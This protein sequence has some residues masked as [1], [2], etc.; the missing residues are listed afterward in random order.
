M[1]EVAE[2]S[3]IALPVFVL[4]AARLAKVRDRGELCV[5]R[6][7]G[8]PPVVQVLN[9]SLRFSFPF[10]TSVHVA[11]QMVTHVVAYLL[12]IVSAITRMMKDYTH[13]KFKKVSKLR[14]LAV[15]VL[16]NR[17]KSLLKLLRGQTADRIVG[18]VMVHVREQNGLRECGFDVLSRTPVTVPAGSDLW[19]TMGN[20]S[21][22]GIRREP[23]AAITL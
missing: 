6:S 13:M 7:T 1:H 23:D 5:Q 4:S 3:S 17:V 19:T 21:F 15:Q 20:V 10:E 22:F 18:R 12:T 9:S 8:V 14:Q 16:V 2:A 11:D